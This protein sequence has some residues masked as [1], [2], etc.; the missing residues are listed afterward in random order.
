MRISLTS[1]QRAELSDLMAEH[2]EQRDRIARAMLQFRKAGGEFDMQSFQERMREEEK[3][4]FERQELDDRTL[5]RLRATL[6]AEQVQR[7]GG[8]EPPSR[9]R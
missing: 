4:R 6:T 5:G 3:L 7:L 2:R 9:P 1:A 8:L